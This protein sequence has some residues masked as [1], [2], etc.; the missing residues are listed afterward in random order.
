MHVFLVRH[1]ECFGNVDP[2]TTDPDSDLTPLGETQARRV[3]MRLADL[4]VTHL[5]SSP[6]LRAV[7]TAEIITAHANIAAFDVWMDLREGNHGAYR[8][9]PRAHLAARGPKAILP[10]ELEADGWLHETK[11]NPEFVGRCKRVVTRIKETFTHN[12]RVA[13]V[14]H[15]L[16]GNNLLHLFLGISLQQPIWFELAN[17]SITG[18]RFVVDPAGERPNWELLPPVDVEVAYVNDIRHLHEPENG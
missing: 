2:D 10:N 18:V 12:D 6:L 13:V 11:N 17:G 5:V 8:C 7:A 15:G 3:G 16:V 1:G 9:R 4:K 14:T